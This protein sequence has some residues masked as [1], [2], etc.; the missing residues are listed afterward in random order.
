MPASDPRVE[1]RRSRRLG[2][3][4]LAVIASVVVFERCPVSKTPYLF[5]LGW[6]SLRLRGLGWRDVGLARPRNWATTAVG[7]SAGLAMEALELTVT[8]P[9][10]IK[11]TG[12]KPDFSDFPAL[13]GNLKLLLIGLAFTWTLAAFGEEMVWRGYLMNRVVGLFNGSCRTEW[14]IS[15][16]LVNAAFGLAHRYQGVTGVLDEALMGVIL[17]LIYLASRRNLTIAIVAHGVADSTDVFLFFVG[18]YPGT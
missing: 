15:L 11:I 5:A 6:I 4:E 13:H 8:Q 7:V 2:I 9:L 16:I 17:G 1:T 10:L 12:R 3:A 14:T 18:R